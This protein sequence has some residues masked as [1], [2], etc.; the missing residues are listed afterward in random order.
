MGTLYVDR[1]GIHVRLDGNAL[2]FYRNGER[3][4]TVPIFPLKR[5]VVTGNITIESS[6]LCKLAD[7]NVTV[8]FLSGR[9]MKFHGML[10]GRLHS[11][12]ILR[13]RQFEKS[14][15][16]KKD[17]R[18]FAV[19]FSF[20]LIGR[21]I[22]NQIDF[23]NEALA[24]RPDLRFPL[25]S[26]IEKIS[27]IN[28]KLRLIKT[29]FEKDSQADPQAILELL[30]GYEGS[31]AA[32][33][34]SGYTELFPPSL[35]FWNRNRRPPQDPV[36]SMLSLCYT[37]I[38]YEMVREIET[39]GL[40]PTIGFYHQFEYGRESLACDMVELFRQEVDRFVWA[41]FRDRHFTARDFLIDK[42]RSCCYLKKQARSRFYP[43]YEEWA[44]KKR[45]LFTE[46]VR[47]LARNILGEE[48]EIYE[49]QN[50]LSE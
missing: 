18:S 39:I 6:V 41:I 3:E 5:V 19:H 44:K 1:K 42:E 11:N 47:A 31:A 25:K 36:N 24:R 30:R 49:G 22:Q 16:G 23:L 12:G 21:K 35:M 32:S 48:W 17:A 37:L 7:Q 15:L 8:I 9:R 28:D 27:R 34:F 29:E 43:L 38:H 33:Y 20:D 2:A 26:S 10:H 14:L 4:G 40:D 13:I 50:A 45:P 46:E